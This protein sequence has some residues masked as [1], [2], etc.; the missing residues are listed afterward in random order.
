MTWWS[1]LREHADVAEVWDSQATVFWGL[2]AVGL[3]TFW[4]GIGYAWLVIRFILWLLITILNL[5]LAIS[6]YQVPLPANTW[7]DFAVE[8]FLTAFSHLSI[9]WTIFWIGIV[10]VGVYTSWEF[11]PPRISE[12]LL[13]PWQPPDENYVS[14]LMQVKANE[15]Q[16]IS[17]GPGRRAS[18]PKNHNIASPQQRARPRAL[19]TDE[20][21]QIA[22]V[23]AGDSLLERLKS[24]F[25]N[26]ILYM[27]APFLTNIIAF[28]LLLLPRPQTAT[29]F[30]LLVL[31]F[32]NSKTRDIGDYIT[33]G[34][35]NISK[36]PQALWT[37]IFSTSWLWAFLVAAFLVGASIWGLK[38][39]SLSGFLLFSLFVLKILWLMWRQSFPDF[40]CIDLPNIIT[41]YW[42]WYLLATLSGLAFMFIVNTGIATPLVRLQELYDWFQLSINIHST[43]KATQAGDGN[44][45]FSPRTKHSPT[46]PPSSMPRRDFFPRAPDDDGGNDIP[47]AEKP[48]PSPKLFLA[49]VPENDIRKVLRWLLVTSILGTFI[50]YSFWFAPRRDSEDSSSVSPGMTRLEFPAKIVS[51]VKPSTPLETSTLD[52]S[53]TTRVRKSHPHSV[54]LHAP[55][56]PTPKT[57]LESPQTDKKD[58]PVKS[59]N[60]SPRKTLEPPVKFS[61]RSSGSTKT[62]SGSSIRGRPSERSRINSSATRE[63]W[64]VRKKHDHYSDITSA[65]PGTT[66][67][68]APSEAYS[69]TSSA[70]H[71]GY[72]GREEDARSS[73]TYSTTSKPIPSQAPSKEPSAVSSKKQ[74]GRLSKDKKDKATTKGG[75]SGNVMLDSETQSAH[76][77]SSK[78]SSGTT[79]VNTSAKIT[80]KYARISPAPKSL[81][82]SDRTEFSPNTR[83]YPFTEGGSECQSLLCHCCQLIIHPFTFLLKV[84]FSPITHVIFPIL[85][86]ILNLGGFY[87]WLSDPWEIFS[88]FQDYDIFRE[89]VTALPGDVWDCVS[90]ESCLLS[91][92][93]TIFYVGLNTVA[94]IVLGYVL[95]L[96][97]RVPLIVILGRIAI[98]LPLSWLAFFFV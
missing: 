76:I 15:K 91:G 86:L 33:D 57:S 52:P 84:I 50:V 19:V 51:P 35:A 3:F 77:S 87:G 45:Q 98:W 40:P 43:E 55:P 95:K 80:S 63:G 53:G 21:S 10:L 69:V 26:W 66:S 61:L 11:W 36:L 68:K 7:R 9:N 74:K 30:G 37:I 13:G 2:I 71:K 70:S 65:S 88:P 6:G 24:R 64:P 34:E 92:S 89:F 47:A 81:Y 97:N 22:H 90:D 94:I 23:R 18:L 60:K 62:G 79:S 16:Q 39:T 8:F 83:P 14:P 54:P 5:L 93:M 82:A 31:Y 29:L 75:W 1:D 49:Y 48:V 28:L 27:C 59:S 44:M 41:P 12:R 4:A 73:S 20:D 58:R 46:T 25:W 56:I 78:K 32:I 72:T 96:A 67:I 42:P 38:N 85:R 17:V